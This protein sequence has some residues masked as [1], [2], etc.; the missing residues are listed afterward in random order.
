MGVRYTGLN[1]VSLP[2]IS[3]LF[4]RFVLWAWDAVRHA[5]VAAPYRNCRQNQLM[6]GMR[7]ETFHRECTSTPPML[8][9]VVYPLLQKHYAHGVSS[10]KSGTFD[11]RKTCMRTTRFVAETVSPNLHVHNSSA[12]QC[13][14]C[15]AD[16]RISFCYAGGDLFATFP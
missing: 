13:S 14:C 4:M 15:A 16:F 10:S 2:L 8:A 1:R 11:T 9:Y 3:C 6:T 5:V 12:Q 7:R